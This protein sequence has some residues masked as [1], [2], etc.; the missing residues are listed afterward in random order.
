[1]ADMKK[2]PAKQSQFVAVGKRFLKR[3]VSVIGL[4][5]LLVLII[6]S[7][8][9][10]L[11]APYSYTKTDPFLQNAKPSA[12]HWFGTDDLGRDVLSRLLYGGRYSLSLSFVSTAIMISVAMI[13]GSIAGYFGGMADTLI[14]RFCDILQSIPSMLLCICVS[15][16]LGQGFIP[17]AVAL[18][19]GGMT[20]N[21]RLLRASMMSVREQEFVEAARAINCSKPRIIF[22]HV[23]K[24]S[25]APIIVNTA[26]DFG[27]KIMASAGLSF[28]G[29]GVQAPTA[30]WGAMVSA[31]KAYFRNAPHVVIIPAIAIALAV[32]SFN[33]VG[34]G[35]RDAFDP[36]MKR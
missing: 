31:G 15:Q 17:T 27:M 35:L 19:I 18:S 13:L 3:K 7:V 30:E 32:L 23:V 22:R 9:A 20:G 28:I 16:A 2:R 26:G 24:N 10:P 29:L 14:L 11:L 21:V 6:L 4:S 5:I 34:D 33:L 8:C 25:L 12:E 1:M 36:K